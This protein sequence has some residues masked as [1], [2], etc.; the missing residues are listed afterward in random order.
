MAVLLISNTGMLLNIFQTLD[1]GEFRDLLWEHKFTDEHQ[2]GKPRGGRG[3]GCGRESIHRVDC[4]RAGA[5][6][7]G[8]SVLGSE[9]RVDTE[10]TVLCPQPF[11]G[12]ETGAGEMEFEN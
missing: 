2:R 3:R 5:G 6:E 10:R 1:G 11:S 9:Q 7:S 12:A 4:S 8:V